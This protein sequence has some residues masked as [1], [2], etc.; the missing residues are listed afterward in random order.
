MQNSDG[1]HP[2][3]R[4]AHPQPEEHQPRSA[5]QPVDRDHRA[6][7]L[8]Q[9]LTRLRHL[10]CRGSAAL[11]RIAVGLRPAVSAVDG[12]AGCRPDRRAVAGDF[13]RA[14]GDFAQPAVDRRHR[15]R[16]PR[17]PAPAVRP[18]RHAV[19]PGAQP[20][21]GGAD[22]VADGRCR[23]GA[24]GRNEADDPGA[25]G[26]QP[27]G[28]AAGPVRRT[29][30][31]GLCAGAR[32]RHGLRNRRRAEADQDAEAQ[33]RC[34]RRPPE[35]ARRHAPAPRRVV[36]DGAAPCR[37][38]GH[39]AG[40]GQRRRTPV[41]GQV[42]LPGLLV[43]AAGTGAAPVLVQQPDGRLPEVRRPRASSSSSTPSASSPSRP[44]SLAGGAIRGWDKKNQ[45]YF[46]IIES[47]AAHY[48]FSVDTPWNDLP[49]EFRTAGALRFRAHRDQF[50]LPERAG[51]ALRPQPHLRG[52]H[53]QSRTALPRQRL[54]RGAR[55]TGQVHQQFGLPD[56]RRHPPA[57][58]GAPRARRRQDA[59][60]NQPPAARRGA[61]L[62]QLPAAGRRQGAG[63]REDPQ[64]N[65]RPPE[66]PDQ[67]RPRLPVPRALGGNA[68]RRRGA[69]HPAG[70]ADRLR[71]DRRH[72]RARRAVDRPAPARQR[73]PAADAEAPARHGQHGDRRRA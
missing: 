9:V 14:E 56:L 15:H 36:R 49:E 47:L 66:L 52:H 55:G 22:G 8:G 13:H 43:C 18:R 5:A 4:R 3:P 69:A 30:R 71:A 35:G 53:P 63:G 27:Q 20:A 37:W 16:N 38:P 11:R 44:L 61:Q 65:H 73:P 28:R 40:N 59:A 21:A 41:L 57:R 60:R 68:V 19:L 34:R 48:G 10:V 29:A 70:L 39:R 54:E 26:R 6:V 50:P 23:A 72:V 1:I 45:F 32:R 25:G 42:R 62:L 31:P 46:Q 64:G 51:H 17:L 33:R 7:R 2:H 12:E 58:R 24:A 67:R